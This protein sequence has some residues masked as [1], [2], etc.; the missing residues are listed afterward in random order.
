MDRCE[1]LLVLRRCQSSKHD[2]ES[3]PLCLINGLLQDHCE[4]RNHVINCTPACRIKACSEDKIREK[5]DSLWR[6]TFRSTFLLRNWNESTPITLIFS[7]YLLDKSFKW[8]RIFGWQN[9]TNY[10][11]VGAILT[12]HSVWLAAIL[13]PN[14]PP[15]WRRL[16]LIYAVTSS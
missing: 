4:A 14:C 2:D 16:A 7:M 13:E 3:T 8:F 10:S 5:I 1:K 6:K 11:L 12:V 15:T 9:S